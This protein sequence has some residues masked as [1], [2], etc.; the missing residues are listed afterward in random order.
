MAESASSGPQP[1]REPA[2]SSRQDK[3]HKLSGHP[4]S[5]EAWGELKPALTPL[6]QAELLRDWIEIGLQYSRRKRT[7]F[8]RASSTL[9]AATILLSGASTIILGVQNLDFWAGIGFALVALTTV[10]AA[11]EPFFNWR[12]RWVLMEE[13]VYEFYRLRDDLIMAVAKRDVDRL[14]NENVAEYYAR[15]SRIWDETSERWMEYRRAS[16]SG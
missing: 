4:G 15:Y 16:E 12:S 3:R 10:V 1:S 6:Q 11:I 13:Q 8:R 9:K 7:S 14:T 2:V 5:D